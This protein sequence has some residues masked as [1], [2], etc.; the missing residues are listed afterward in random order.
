M[1]LHHVS[2]WNSAYANGINIPNGDRWPGLWA[3][4]ANPFRDRM[5]AQDQARLDVGYG[6]GER[7][8]LDLFLPEGSPK[9]LVVYVHGGFWRMLDKSFGSHLAA[10]PLAH[11]YAVAMPSYTLTPQARVTEIGREIAAAIEKAGSLVDGPIHLTGHSA[12]GQLV[13]RMA[14][15]TSPLA[16]AVT[17]RIRH[18]V[19]LSGLHDLRPMPRLVTNADMRFDAAEAEAESPALLT[20]IEGTRLTCW[21]GAAERAEFVRQSQLLA[22][23]WTGL[24]ASTAF[25]AEPDRHHFNIVD[26]LAD[27]EHPLVGCLLS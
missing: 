3:D 21:V 27:P 25:Y 5:L 22:N 17:R 24:G 8:K 1:I 11:G 7:N 9:G 2:D 16:G 13:T 6:S 18:V 12:G 15:T 23:I 10:G 26:G 20:P 14:T 4:A 19:S